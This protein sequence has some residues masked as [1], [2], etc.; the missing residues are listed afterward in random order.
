MNKRTGFYY[1]PKEIIIL[2]ILW[3]LLKPFW[4]FSPRHLWVF[5]RWILRIFGAEIGGNVK[6]YPSAKISQPWN[7]SIKENSTIGWDV[8][9]YCL[10][11]I[12]IGKNVI[13]SQGAHICAGTH[14]YKN[15]N[16]NLIKKKIIINNN[17]W[18]AAESF[19]GP[20]VEIGEKA[21]VGARAVVFSNVLPENIVI[22]NPA[23]K[24]N[25]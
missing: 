9:L 15:K 5:R 23:K 7:L 12:N 18:I 22:G 8:K 2:R 24:I 3:S 13:I 17:A 14:D 10:G 11:K 25:K 21:V 4:K 16:F 20:G 19:I 1:Y 6:I